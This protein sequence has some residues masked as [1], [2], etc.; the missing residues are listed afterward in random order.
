MVERA[1][2]KLHMAAAHCRRTW[3]EQPSQSQSGHGAECNGW[4]F[5]CPTALLLEDT[6]KDLAECICEV[7]TRTLTFR[8]VFSTFN[9]RQPLRLTWAE[10]S[11]CG[12]ELRTQ[13]AKWVQKGEG[14]PRGPR[15]ACSISS[16]KLVQRTLWHFI[17]HILNKGFR[18]HLKPVLRG[19]PMPELPSS[20]LQ[21]HA[22]S[23]VLFHLL[24][25]ILPVVESS[26]EVPRTQA[27]TKF[28]RASSSQRRLDGAGATC[29]PGRAPAGFSKSSRLSPTRNPLVIS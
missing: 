6:R 2:E 16:E 22:L 15:H 8:G 25:F 29:P 11:N 3:K 4:A 13:R 1:A 18:V 27:N 26:L 17:C 24:F 12:S 28:P 7:H 10:E 5:P 20:T 9:L 23:P 19:A 14:R 21:A